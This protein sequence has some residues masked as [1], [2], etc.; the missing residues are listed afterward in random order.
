MKGPFF[1][2][3]DTHNSDSG[4]ESECDAASDSGSDDEGFSPSQLNQN[5]YTGPKGGKRKFESPLVP[6]RTYIYHVN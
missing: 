4:E 6:L 2:H 3:R 5:A 1:T